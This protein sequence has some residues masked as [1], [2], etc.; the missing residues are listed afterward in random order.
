MHSC[1]CLSAQC[2]EE[3]AQFIDHGL[4]LLHRTEVSSLGEAPVMP[5]IIRTLH[6][7]PRPVANVLFE[8]SDTGRCVDDR[9]AMMT[10]FPRMTSRLGVVSRGSA[11]AFRQP[12]EH[13]RS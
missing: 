12:V 10:C 5:Q 7:A 11:K 4:R 2:T 3:D 9:L 6:H 8:Q 13:H 1:C